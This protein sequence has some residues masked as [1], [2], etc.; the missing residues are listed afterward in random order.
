MKTTIIICRYPSSTSPFFPTSVLSEKV[1]V[2]SFMALYHCVSQ[3]FV[4]FFLPL[5]YKLAE[6]RHWV[7]ANFISFRLKQSWQST[8]AE[9]VLNNPL[10]YLL[11]V[12]IFHIGW[13]RKLKVHIYQ[14]SFWAIKI[15][16]EINSTMTLPRMERF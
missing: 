13:Y 3:L 5:D 4:D 14:T 10:A 11:F 2:S 1:A 7:L 16:P 6:G 8:I 15:W 12:R 9:L